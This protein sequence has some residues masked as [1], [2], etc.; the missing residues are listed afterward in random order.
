MTINE[1]F[2]NFY[3]FL[4]PII[5]TFSIYIIL[6][7]LLYI[8]IFIFNILCCSN[9]LRFHIIPVGV[10]LGLY[11]YLYWYAADINMFC[12]FGCGDMWWM[13]WSYRPAF[14]CC[15]FL[16]PVAYSQYRIIFKSLVA[17]HQQRLFSNA[18]IIACA[19]VWI[20]K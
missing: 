16:W 11:C 12:W 9:K 5:A 19:V 17:L 1:V 3:A 13:W 4:L 20:R 10:T 7:T 18:G 15:I 6:F 14:T 2:V 8:N